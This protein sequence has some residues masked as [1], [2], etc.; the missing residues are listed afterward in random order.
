VT[1]IPQ[2]TDNGAAV[3]L[4]A[5]PVRSY[6]EW[7]PL[8]EVIVGVMDGAAVPEWDVAVAASMPSRSEELFQSRA[9]GA[10][11]IEHARAAG[12]ELEGLVQVLTEGGV[13][14][15][16]PDPIS[17]RRPFGTPNWR[18]P[19]G[20]YGAMPRDLLLIVGDLMIEAPMAW[21]SRYF[22]IDAYRSLLTDYFRRG[23]RWVSA[24]RPQL[25]EEWY[26]ADY[27][28]E[29]P[30][31]SG[32]YLTSE[33]EPTFDAADFIRCGRDIFAQRSHVTN[34]LGI[35]WVSR[36]L[37]AEY[38]V[39][40]IE[41]IDPSPMHIDASFM[42]LAPGKLLLNPHRVQAVPAVLDGWDVRWAPEPALPRD[43]QLYMSSAWVSMN[44]LMLDEKRVVVEASE[45]PL[46]EMLED[47][48]LE[49][50]PVEF[51]NVMRFGGS[52]HCVTADVRR[53]GELLSYV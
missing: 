30:Y 23:A 14:V 49:T 15:V 38:R 17:Y 45:T 35:D 50:V 22:E 37:G 39:H 47:W 19:G 41:V 7:D 36:Q 5:S 21:R 12:E 42:P 27:D 8:E 46:I 33:H 28:R 9:G 44:V 6:T 3:D 29:R 4:S 32:R 24:P 16:R 18:S 31:E 25:L 26:N 13:H 34:R 43:H 52:F 1:M 53:Q 11:P 51:R 40:V 2:Q 48:G 10:F 20:L